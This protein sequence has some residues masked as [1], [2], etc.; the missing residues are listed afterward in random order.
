[1]KICDMEN[2]FVGCNNEEHFKVLICAPDAITAEK[3]VEEYRVD[4]NLAGKFCIAEF[5]NTEINI[6]CSYILV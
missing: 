5:D 1:M 3:I 6:D 4:M 2:L